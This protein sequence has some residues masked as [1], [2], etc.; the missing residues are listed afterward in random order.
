VP[1]QELPEFP[2]PSPAPAPSGAG[3]LSSSPPGGSCGRFPPRRRLRCVI[4]LIGGVLWWGALLR[5]GAGPPADPWA[6]AVAAGG[7][8]LGLIPLHAVPVS[9]RRAG[10][11]RSRAVRLR[12]ARSRHGGQ[13]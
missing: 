6:S 13:A 3:P 4:G 8:G 11:D 5:L 10:P 7:W 12:A 1:L 2:A 9:V